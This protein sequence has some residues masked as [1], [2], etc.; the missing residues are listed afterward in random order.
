MEDVIDYRKMIRKIWKKGDRSFSYDMLV[1]KL[2]GNI[3][4]VKMLDEMIKD[5]EIL[6]VDGNGNYKLLAKTS[7][8]IGKFIVCKNG[9]GRILS[10]GGEYFV[11]PDNN[12][13]AVSNDVVLFDSNVVGKNKSVKI[14][15]VM[16]RDLD[17]VLG[18]VIKIGDNFFVAA[19]DYKYKNLYIS[20]LGNEYIEGSKVLVKLG[21]RI[22]DNFYIGNVKKN[23]GHKDDPFVDILMEAYRHGIYDEFSEDVIHEL[24][25]VPYSV[26]D[27]D[28]IGRMDFSNK[29]IFTIDG[30]HT[31]DRDDAISLEVLDNGNFSLGVH[32]ADVSHY[33]KYNSF[34][35][36]EARERGTSSYLSNT[37]IPMLPHKLSNG[38]CSLNQ[39]VSRLCISCIMEI[40]SSGNIVRSDI[41]PS[42]I[43]S[44]K[45]MNYDDVNSILEDGEDLPDYLLYK[46]TLV[47]MDR[48]AKL[49][50]KRRELTGSISF[51][52]GELEVMCDDSGVASLVCVR[53]QRSAERLIEDF[54]IAANETVAKTMSGYPFIYR[55]HDCYRD[56][57]MKEFLEM[58][59]IIGI[60]F[61][62]KSD[63]L[64]R[65]LSLY[66]ADKGS[67]GAF[68][69]LLLIRT[70]SKAIYDTKNIGHYGL[71]IEYYCHFTSPIRRYP[72]LTVHRLIKDYKFNEGNL[73]VDWDT[74]LDN[75]ASHSS[76]RE[77]NAFDCEMSVLKMKCAEYMQS[78]INEN[79]VGTIIS[80]NDKCIRVRLDNMIEGEVPVSS[81]SGDYRYNKDELTLTSTSNIVSYYLGDRLNLVLVDADKSKK[82]INFLII[83]KIFENNYYRYNEEEREKVKVYRAKSDDMYYNV[84]KGVNRKRTKR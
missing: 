61:N 63:N 51:D 79:F 52:T 84:N 50:R 32:I 3:D 18:E 57:K 28:K 39:N 67:F 20:L 81:L 76:S 37:V 72:D 6:D 74:T 4:A 7:L 19:D 66:L 70:F 27:H 83:A 71:G 58:L 44:S 82:S 65:D 54:M 75:I 21:E 13:C 14:I 23:L 53:N 68:L 29:L 10:D 9:D 35:D 11:S 60:D 69:Q 73:S 56:D 80:M 41:V 36:R 62:P 55:V 77:R 33:V 5:N 2:D 1:Q 34:I 17:T 49:L 42:V 47:L 45:E 24:D 59:K 43:K 15:K 30:K 8:K 40:D 25:S 46:D 12:V 31:K 38:I 16:E 48:V 22:N 78:H 26:S 64:G